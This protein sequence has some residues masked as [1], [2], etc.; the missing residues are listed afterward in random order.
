[1]RFGDLRVGEAGQAAVAAHGDVE[2]QARVEGGRLSLRGTLADLRVD[3]VSGHTG[4][5]TLAPCF[6]DVVPALRDS[7]VTSEGLPLDLP[8]PDRL[9]RVNLV[10][11]T[12]LV[13]RGLEGEVTGSPP[14]LRLRGQARLTRREKP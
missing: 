6:S 14:T 12:D 10:L 2:A 11:G 13:L 5:W 9:L 8:I 7:G 1:V 4:A 3:C